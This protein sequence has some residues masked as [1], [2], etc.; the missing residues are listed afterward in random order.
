MKRVFTP[1]PHAASGATLDVA[2]CN[3]S[4]KR[5]LMDKDTSRN[6][7][8][9]DETMTDFADLA[10]THEEVIALIKEIPSEALNWQP[11][12]EEWSL[13]QTISHLAHANDFYVMIVEE[14]RANRFSIVHLHRGLDGWQRMSAT[15]AEIAQCRTISEMLDCFENAYQRMLLLL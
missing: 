5:G 11:S 14:T 12:K 8:R 2:D 3:I 7:P 4:G 10:A 9:S 15:D 13:K 1:C 6:Q